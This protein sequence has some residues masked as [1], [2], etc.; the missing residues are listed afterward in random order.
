[1]A[2]AWKKGNF[3]LAS[4]SDIHVSFDDLK[5]HFNDNTDGNFTDIPTPD[6]KVDDA[7]FTLIPAPLGKV[8]EPTYNNVPQPNEPTYNDIGVTT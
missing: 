2:N 4:F 8:A 6:G 1:M 3:G 5:Q 7:V